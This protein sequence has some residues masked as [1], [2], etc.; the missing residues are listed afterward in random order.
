MKKLIWIILIFSLHSCTQYKVWKSNKITKKFNYSKPH[1]S[2]SD[3][4]TK[5]RAKK[6]VGNVPYSSY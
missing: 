4:Y 6:V 1:Q 2:Y 5:K 3:K